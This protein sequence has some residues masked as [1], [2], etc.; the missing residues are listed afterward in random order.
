MSSRDLP[1][2][3][4]LLKRERAS[5]GQFWLFLI[6]EG[7]RASFDSFDS[8]EKRRKEPV[9]T[10]DCLIKKREKEPVLT[11]LTV[12][13]D[14]FFDREKKEGSR[15]PPG[16]L[17]GLDTTLPIHPPLHTSRVHHSLLPPPGTRLGATVGRATGASL[18]CCRTDS[19]T[20]G[21]YHAVFRL[22]TEPIINSSVKQAGP[23]SL[24]ITYLSNC[25]QCLL[26]SPPVST[27]SASREG[28]EGQFSQNCH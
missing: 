26:G 14:S 22:G 12:F 6:K 25:H 2:S 19:Y 1:F 21:S 18:G 10:F 17:P 27:M 23:G 13:F 24:D 20:N 5:F 11:V 15:Y 8:F 28:P 3:Q 7:E 4:K 16:V 9:L